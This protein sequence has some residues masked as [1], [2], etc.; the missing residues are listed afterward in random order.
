M[1]ELGAGVGLVGL[2]ACHLGSSPTVAVLTDHDPGVLRQI[3]Y[4]IDEQDFPEGNTS[5]SLDL[6][7]GEEGAATVA[8]CIAELGEAPSLILGSDVIYSIGIVAPLFWTAHELLRAAKGNGLPAVFLMCSSFSYEAQI[9]ATIDEKCR[10]YGFERCIISCALAEGGP[11]IQSFT[12]RD[13]P[14]SP[15]EGGYKNRLVYQLQQN[16]GELQQKNMRLKA[17]VQ[18]LYFLQIDR[19]L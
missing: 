13:K 7:W 11:R 8:Q 17:R 14:S 19:C 12:L 9:E 18:D 2:L 4:N 15:V 6:E 10:E 1:V 3:D 16:L 5:T